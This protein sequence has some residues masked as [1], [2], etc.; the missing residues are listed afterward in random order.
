MKQTARRSPRGNSISWN[1]KIR[2]NKVLEYVLVGSK[3]A[4]LGDGKI[5]FY[6]YNFPSLAGFSLLLCVIAS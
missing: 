4:H 1:F 2:L 6:V 5:S 3:P